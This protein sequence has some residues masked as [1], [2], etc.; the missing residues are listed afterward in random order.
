[1]YIANIEQNENT[2]EVNEIAFRVRLI[3]KFLLFKVQTRFTKN[4]VDL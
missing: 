3:A 4:S 2:E 1:M